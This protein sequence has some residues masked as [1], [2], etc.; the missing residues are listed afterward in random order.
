MLFNNGVKLEFTSYAIDQI[1]EM[2]Y[3]NQFGARPLKRV[4]QHY[5][6]NELSK[7]LLSGKVHKDS[8]ILVDY[9]EEGFIFRNKNSH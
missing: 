6:L 3:D 8:D 1:C 9:F 7:M 5:I 4:L 2:G